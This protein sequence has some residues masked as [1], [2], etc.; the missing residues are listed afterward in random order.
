MIIID[1]RETTLYEKLIKKNIEVV[2]QQLE[3]GDIHITFNDNIFVYERKTASDLLASIKDGRYKEQ[4]IRMTST[5]KNCNYIIE[6][7]TIVSSNSI[8]L[9]SYLHSIYRDNFNVFF[10]KNVEETAEFLYLLYNK[11]LANP[12]KFINN[13]ENTKSS[14]IDNYKIKSKKIENIDK[15]NC[16]LLQL[17]QIPTI[18]KEIAKKIKEQY[19]T[20]RILIKT[21]E[22]SDNKTLLLTKINGIGKNKANK[23]LEFLDFL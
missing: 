23:I 3:I 5:Y 11:I 18:S 19:A 8:L 2:K 22:E 12:E 9:S 17:S 4:K 1:S 6:E 7:D 14:Y 13:I 16:Y 20:I 21:L 15:D 10:T